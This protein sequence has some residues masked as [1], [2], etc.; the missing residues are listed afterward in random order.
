MPRGRALVPPDQRLPPQTGQAWRYSLS[1]ERTEAERW[2][3]LAVDRRMTRSAFV[4][5]CIRRGLAQIL[6]EEATDTRREQTAA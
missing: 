5:E 1:T 2:D 6:A 4:I 3:A